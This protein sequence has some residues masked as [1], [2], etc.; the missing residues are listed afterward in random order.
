MSEE[1][2]LFAHNPH[3]DVPVNTQKPLDASWYESGRWRLSDTP[4]TDIAG[5]LLR[6]PV[7]KTQ[8]AVLERHTECRDALLG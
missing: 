4:Y 3:T 7:S 5:R 6:G 2:L 1:S 8:K